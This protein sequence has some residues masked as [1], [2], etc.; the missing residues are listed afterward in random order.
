M[1]FLNQKLLSAATATAASGA[2]RRGE[3]CQVEG[4]AASP[5]EGCES[6][7]RSAGSGTVSFLDSGLK[8]WV[9]SFRNRRLC[10]GHKGCSKLPRMQRKPL[11]FE[12]P[13]LTLHD[14][15]HVTCTI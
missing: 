6:S 14:P 1:H 12:H 10:S 15:L 13:K 7:R 8:A 3:S 11:S 9:L 5:W 4:L 2:E